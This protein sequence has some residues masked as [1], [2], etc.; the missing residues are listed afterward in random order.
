MD[1]DRTWLKSDRWDEWRALETDQKKGMPPP[2]PQEAYPANAVLLDL[3]PPEQLTV[4][5]M[6]LIEALTQRRSRR[7]YTEDPLSLEELS[8]LLWA[9][10]GVDRDATHAIRDWF[11][12]QGHSAAARATAPLRTVPS[13]GARHPFETYLLVHSVSGLAPGLYRYLPMEHKLLF[14]RAGAELVDQATE[15]F[16][17]WVQ[18]SA[19]VFL[20]TAVP[21]RSEWR[22]AFVA[23]KMIAQESGHIC[24]NL[25]LAAES[26]GAGAC[27]IGAYDQAQVDALL[28]V[29]GEDE[30][31]IYVAPVGKV[32]PAG[33]HFEH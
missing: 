31:T 11:S 3:V 22:Y 27:A 15:A 8:F 26:I 14:L 29:D 32:A 1:P 6:P 7:K 2:A 16:M 33:Y 13:A 19:A 24:Q 23:H 12:G 30:F 17:R 9:T 21:Y 4:G 18:K 20:W 28:G 25:Y 10:Q 5:R